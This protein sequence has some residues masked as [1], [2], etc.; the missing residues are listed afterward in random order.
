M[1]GDPLKNFSALIS[2][3]LPQKSIFLMSLLFFGYRISNY[4]HFC[5]LFCEL[6]CSWRILGHARFEIIYIHNNLIWISTLWSQK[7]LTV[8]S[9]K[10]SL[11]KYLWNLSRDCNWMDFQKL[12]DLKIQFSS[13]INFQLLNVNK[14]FSFIKKNLENCYTQKKS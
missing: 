11:L 1:N 13:Q 4:E 12:F 10:A 6:R 5:V 7:L 2:H 8:V 3:E 9:D 14:Y